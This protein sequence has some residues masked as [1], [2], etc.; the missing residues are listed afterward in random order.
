MTT[1]Q[2]IKALKN[3]EKTEARTIL[4]AETNGKIEAIEEI[5]TEDGVAD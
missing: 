5:L 3:L 2:K 1:L 4:V